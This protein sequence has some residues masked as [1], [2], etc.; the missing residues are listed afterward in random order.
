[1]D[2]KESTKNIHEMIKNSTEK[3]F[4]EWESLDRIEEPSQETLEFSKNIEKLVK[5]EVG[6]GEDE[7]KVKKSIQQM[8]RR[9]KDI[10]EIIYGNNVIKR[11]EIIDEYKGYV[12]PLRS[13]A[14]YQLLPI[15]DA[16]TPIARVL[17]WNV[18]HH[19]CWVIWF[20]SPVAKG[21]Q[22][23]TEG[24]YLVVHSLNEKESEDYD[25]LLKFS[26]YPCFGRSDGIDILLGYTE[27][28][29][30]VEFVEKFIHTILVRN[31]YGDSDFLRFL[32]NY[33]QTVLKI[34][35]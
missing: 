8:I 10:G 26:K 19:P 13:V 33:R 2:E 25:L 1:M 34:M 15:M 31:L 28:D 16:R 30:A 14:Y 11:I 23:R 27:I 9:R 20:T 6:I 21:I 12:R 22:T 35:S 3:I 17:E 29:N 5:E 18:S 7:I 24:E 4:K 32:Q